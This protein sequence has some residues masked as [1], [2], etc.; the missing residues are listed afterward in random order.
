MREDQLHYD[1]V[2]LAPVSPFAWLA[3]AA[4]TVIVHSMASSGLG[5]NSTQLQSAVLV[6]L[7]VGVLAIVGT[8]QKIN[9]LNG[10]GRRT[11]AGVMITGF[12]CGSAAVMYYGFSAYI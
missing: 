9:Q 12:L 2:R 1:G 6:T 11:S 7:F 4:L 8:M 10:R 5:L 3:T